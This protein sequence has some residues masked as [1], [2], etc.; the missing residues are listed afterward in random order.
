MLRFALLS[1]LSLSLSLSAQGPAVGQ[2]QTQPENAVVARIANN[3][4]RQSDLLEYWSIFAQPAQIEQM[5]TNPEQYSQMQVRFVEA[6]LLLNKAKKD[7]LDKTQG[8]RE[9][10]I[11]ATTNL[12]N[13]MLV[14]EYVDMRTQELDRL[15][16]PSEEQMKAYYEESKGD[17]K[18]P[19]LASARHILVA[20]RSNE[21]QTDKLSDADALAKIT[22]AATELEGGKSW[23]EVA[24]EYSEDPGSVDNGGLYENFNP[25]QM[26]PEFAQAVQTQEIGK[27]GKPIRTQFG[28]HIVM[29]ESR[30]SAQIQPFDEA[31][32][33]IKP[34]LQEQ[35]RLDTW[36]N[37]INTL[38]IE[39]GYANGA[40]TPK[41]NNAD[42]RTK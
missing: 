33:A 18:T 16:T 27:I 34:K 12:T 14:Q 31:K 28:Y 6:M 22:T 24:K 39:L 29:V 23:Q 5:K 36:G 37:F 21:N 8:F 30:K 1:T 9:K 13:N 3:V 17:Y 38:K 10:S 42:R 7:G 11:K 20:V 2:K 35:M 4:Y 40:E 19:A 25:A 15:S 26:V 32:A 41:V